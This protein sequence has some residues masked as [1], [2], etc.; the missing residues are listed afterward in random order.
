MKKYVIIFQKFTKMAVKE[1]VFKTSLRELKAACTEKGI[2][3]L[4]FIIENVRIY[5][6][7]EPIRD[8]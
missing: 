3:S 7:R 8:N 4:I 2:E 6:F 5:Y 1:E